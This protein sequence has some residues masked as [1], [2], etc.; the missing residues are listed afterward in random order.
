[1][2]VELIY[3]LLAA[4]MVPLSK[5]P[6]FRAMSRDEGG[7]DN[8]NPRA[9]QARMS[10]YGARALAA[11]QNMI[12]AF[13]LFAAGLLA[14]LWAGVDSTWV[15]VLSLSFLITRVAYTWLYVA[16]RASL[17]SL[18]WSIGFFACLGLILL[19]LLGV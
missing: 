2:N 9:Q 12:E 5:A 8:R 4:L 13:P 16:D 10:G 1:M 15:H 3:L 17:R 14:A 6:L 19:A 7:Y 18:V 11:H